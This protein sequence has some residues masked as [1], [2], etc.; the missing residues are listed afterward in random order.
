MP[1]RRKFLLSVASTGAAALGTI[2][3]SPLKAATATARA[4]ADANRSEAQGLVH[5]LPTV[6][7]ERFLIKAS[8]RHPLTNAPVLRIGRNGKV[9]GLRTDGAGECWQFDATGLR[10]STAY[11]LAIASADG[12]AL[13]DP[14]TLRT[15]PAP[16]DRPQ[17]LRVL[18]YTCAGGHDAIPMVNGKT[19]FL[20]LAVRQR[21]LRRALA[22]K[23]DAVIANGDHVYWDLT[24]PRAS[25][26]LGAS[27][28]AKDYAGVF[29]PKQPILGT[30]NERFLKRAGGEQIAPLYGTLCRSTPVFFVQDDHDFFD[31]DEATDEVVT[32]PPKSWMTALARTTQRLYYPEFLPDPTRPNGLPGASALDRPPGVSEWFGTLRYGKLA[33]FLLYSV[34]PTTTLA[35]PSAVFLD[36][37]V[38]TW[39]KARMAAQ[40]TAHLINVPSNPPGWSAGKWGEWYPDVLGPD[41][42]LTTA[43][44]KPYWQTGWL[45]Q[46][47]RLME[48]ASAMSGRVPLFV[49]GDLHA[50]AEGRMLRTGAIDLGKNPVVVVLSGSMGTGD[51]GWPSSFRGIGAMP[52]VHLDLQEDLKPL[53]EN[54][55]IIADL[56]PDKIVL[57]YFR[58]NVRRDSVE[59]LDTLEPFRRTELARPG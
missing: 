11:P 18:I 20:P 36:P 32:F 40:D 50:L 55:F 39:L 35:G 54:G 24:A 43:K 48:A 44:P 42:K 23:P 57:R 26:L 33:E 19:A 34:R 51:Q 58:W 4:S 22:F 14:W 56:T 31:N 1:T 7:H 10:P 46:H 37:E 12:H 28:Q 41:G 9:R 38:E 15:F 45:K 29:D 6:N 53:E 17:T 13:G 2:F 16:D 27:P 5:L 25:P 52:S 3:T 8:F 47:D 21:L 30:A 49:S 59:S